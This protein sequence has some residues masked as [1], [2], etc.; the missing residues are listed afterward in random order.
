MPSNLRSLLIF[1][2]FLLPEIDIISLFSIPFCGDWVAYE[3]KKNREKRNEE[4]D[5]RQSRARIEV[6]NDHRSAKWVFLDEKIIVEIIR[7]IENRIFHRL[8]YS[9]GVEGREVEWTV[10]RK[11]VSRVE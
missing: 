5:T 6:S 11:G 9:G 4:R 3:T 10:I 8:A 2:A 7:A 1:F